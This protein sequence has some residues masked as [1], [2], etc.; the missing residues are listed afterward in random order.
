MMAIRSGLHPRAQH[1]GQ[2]PTAG[3]TYVS[4]EPK[5]NKTVS[6]T[7]VAFLPSYGPNGEA[8]GSASRE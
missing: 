4:Q 6:R 2:H 5:T 7:G 3:V 1:S 8:K